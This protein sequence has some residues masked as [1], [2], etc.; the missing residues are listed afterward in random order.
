MKQRLE[1]QTTEFKAV[2]N[3][4]FEREVVAFLN[5][6]LGGEIYIGIEDNGSV[7]GVKEPDKIQRS[8]AEKL[9]DSIAPSTLGLATI[10]CEEIEGKTVIRVGIASGTEK[11]YHLT[12]YGLTSRG[13]FLRVGST[14]QPIPEN[15]ISALYARHA[16]RSIVDIP[17]REQELTFTQLKIYY[18]GKH[19]DLKESFQKTLGLFTKE[20][21]YNLLAYLLSD[22]NTISVS[23]AKYGGKDKSDLIER[24]E[25]GICSLV[26]SVHMVLDKMQI[27]NTIRTRITPMTRIE[28][29]LVDPTCLRE[30]VINAFVHTDWQYE[31]APVFEIFSDRIS[32]TSTGT[33]PENLSKDDFFDCVSVPRNRE[34]MRIFKDLDMV[35]QLGSGLSRI[36]AKYDL[37][38]YTFMDGFIRVNF[39]FY[40]KDMGTN[41]TGSGTNQ[42]GSGTNQTG[43]GTNQTGS[44]TNQTG[45]GTN[46][47]GSGTNQAG[48]GTN[49][50]EKYK[51][52]LCLI[53]D[54]LKKNPGY[55]VPQ[56]LQE[57]GIAE[58]S[59]KRYLAI[60]RKQGKIGRTGTTRKSF[61]IVYEDENHQG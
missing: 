30:A 23:V 59:V 55:S 54:V 11:P 28:V 38:I 15:K 24:Q 33:L 51:Q 25:C 5:S 56:I 37:H 34:L 3:D 45:S 12:R 20:G 4:K 61:W 48:S 29:P 36:K 50:N 32:I 46:Q 39:P 14:V 9:K 22:D 57:T 47:A 49:R 19:L 40:Q 18:E 13:C 10:T 31:N 43:S 58:R 44:G 2:L 41:Q 52:N 8:I 35:E 17:S 7:I 27:E 26:K 21:T 60:L 42:T 6:P 1:T 16:Q 53:L